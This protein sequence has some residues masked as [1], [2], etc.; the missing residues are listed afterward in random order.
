MDTCISCEERWFKM[1]LITDT[2]C[3]RCAK[4]D[5][6]RFGSYEV[7]IVLGRDEPQPETPNKTLQIIPA[8]PLVDRNCAWK[9]R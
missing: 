7:K 5:N 8:V 9:L 3:R 1:N 6:L 4:P 2:A